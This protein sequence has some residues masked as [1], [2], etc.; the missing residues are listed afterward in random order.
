[1]RVLLI[2]PPFGSLERPSLG[3]HILQA[4]ARARGHNVDVIYSNIAFASRIGEVPYMTITTSSI[5]AMMGERIMGLRSGALLS[6]E[7]LQG[8]N[9]EIQQAAE[10]RHVDA[11][12]LSF[13]KLNAATEAWLAEMTSIINR[14]PYDVIGLSTTFEQTNGMALLAKHCRTLLPHVI[15]VAGGANCEGEMAPAI[16]KLAPEIDIV[17]S[18]ES[19]H[20]FTSFLDQ[21][22]LFAGQHIINALPNS[23][24]G[25]LPRLDYSEYFIQFEHWLPISSLR[26]MDEIR[27]SYESSR[28][29]WWGQKHHCTFCG[30]NGN[31]MGYR[32]KEPE[33]VLSEMAE[34]TAAT[35]VRRFG[36]TDN[37]MPVSYFNSLLPALAEADLSLDIFYEQKANI[38][39]NKVMALKAA[40]VNGIQ[41]GIESLQDDLLRLMKKGTSARQNIALLRYARSVGMEAV[42][43]ILSGFPR[44]RE[45]WYGD[46][47]RL[48]PL[49]VHL[50]PPNGLSKLNFDRFSPYFDKP[51]EYG[52]T[53]MRPQPSYQDAF[54]HCEDLHELAYHFIGECD[55]H[56]IDNSETIRQLKEAVDEWRGLWHCIGEEKIIPC[57]EVIEIDPANYLLIDTR[58]LPNVP[59]MQ[60]ISSDQAS[61]ALSFHNEDSALTHWGAERRVCVRGRNG[62]IPLA[63][64]A[65]EVLHRFERVRAPDLQDA[66]V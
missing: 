28:G 19:E 18:G 6:E 35:G 61:V 29:C 36:M 43:N 52:I 63:C 50:P 30:L 10:A 9:E 1:M 42:W 47:L 66:A 53:D 8:L 60:Q 7:T 5:Q 17:F 4:C 38:S 27:I 58:P 2:I 31:G 34:L 33:Q 12:P 49:I 16:R 57:L 20:A 51:A 25:T 32:Q 23:D 48:V 26:E 40:G 45:E 65:P 39:L 59:F 3:V 15:L 21:P 56:T 44:D 22:E 55:G 54:P 41:P 14:Q 37:I 13:E 46:M 11:A 64:A 24:L 62:Y